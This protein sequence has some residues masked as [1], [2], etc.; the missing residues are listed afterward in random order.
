MPN[1]TKGNGPP[2]DVGAS[3]L[4]AAF[5]A[6]PLPHDIVDFPV[7]DPIMGQSIGKVAIVPLGVEDL[8]VCQKVAAEFTANITKEH[9]KSGEESPAYSKIYSDEA[10]VQIL[11]RALRD[12]NDKTLERRA[13]KAPSL[14]RR[15]PFT[16]D[17][18]AVLL[19]MYMRTCATRGPV[20]ATMTAEEM[21]AW[22]D[23]LEE[24]GAAH[25]LESLTWGG[26][27]DLLMH[28]VARSRALRTRSI[29]S[30]S[31]PDASNET[32]SPVPAPDPSPDSPAAD[33]PDVA[34]V[35]VIEIP[36]E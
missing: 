2:A 22:L 34:A 10:A 15:A 1:E 24:G 28:S 27:T 6:I 14:L 23:R 7:R 21:N 35:D 12:A 5:T 25:P 30:G 26:M 3:E 9:P 17:L 36:K 18:I 8:M 11:W 20:I 31:P 32:A 4:W 19:N 16:G 29:S 13:F 33:A